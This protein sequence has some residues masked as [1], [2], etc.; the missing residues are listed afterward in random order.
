MKPVLV[1]DMMANLLSCAD[2]WGCMRKLAIP[3]VSGGGREGRVRGLIIARWAGHG[4][5][6]RN[7]H[8]QAVTTSVPP[9]FPQSLYLA[10][11]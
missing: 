4:F 9:T 1:T 11:Q 10:Q 3:S 2:V 5:L 7:Q 8:K 6:H